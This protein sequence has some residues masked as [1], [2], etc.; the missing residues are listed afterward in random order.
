MLT[1]DA[2][3]E[4]CSRRSGGA[5]DDVD[6]A[7]DE[8]RGLR[9]L[10]FEIDPVIDHD[11]LEVF[12]I[13]R[14]A[15]HAGDEDHGEG[16]A[17]TLRVP[18][19]ARA[20]F[21]CCA[22]TQAVEDAAR[23]A[24][25]LVAA[26]DFDAAAGIGVHEDGRGAQHIE[27]S[28]GRKQALNQPLLIAFDAERRRVCA[29][30]FVRQMS[31]QEWKCS[32]AGGDGAELGFFAASADEQQV[33]VEEARI[34]FEFSGGNGVGAGIAVAFELGVGGLHGVGGVG[35]ADFGFDHHERD[36]VDEENDVGN[37]AGFGSAG[38]VDAELVDG[39]EGVALRVG[40]V[41][42]LHD[43]IEFAGEFVAIDLGFEEEF[44]DGFV[45]FEQAAGGMAEELV[46]EIVEIA[47]AEPFAVVGGAVDASDGI[48]ED[49]RKQDLAE[50]CR[51]GV[52][53]GSEG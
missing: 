45:G 29:A 2:P 9:K 16:L 13:G 41:D 17:R 3:V 26:N 14:G 35:V 34:A 28:I 19:N 33:R 22:G 47:R 21:G 7:A 1:S 12:E 5:F 24:V 30:G 6:F 15:K 8:A 53:A 18:D 37:D 11:D 39:V 46:R 40:E 31:F 42:E 52:G 20:A 48:A 49:L 43:G 25:L 32:C 51:G 27:Q 50:A 44:V 23:G 10:F 36:A 38:R 4:R